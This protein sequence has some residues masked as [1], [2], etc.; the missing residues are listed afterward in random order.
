MI[1]CLDNIEDMKKRDTDGALEKVTEARKV[2]NRYEAEL[3]N[4]Q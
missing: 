2:L 1:H 4:M 3:K